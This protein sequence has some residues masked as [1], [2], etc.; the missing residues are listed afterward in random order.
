MRILLILLLVTTPLHAGD[1]P[2]F[3]GPAG[4]N[5]SP[6]KGLLTAWPKEGL[7]KLWDCPLGEGYGPPSAAGGKLFHFDLVRGKAVLTARDAVTGKHLWAYDYPCDYQDAFGYEGTRCCPVNDNDRVYIYGPEGQLHCV[8][9]AD[10]KKIWTVDTFKEFNVHPNF[11]GVSSVPI[12]EGDLLIVGVGGS[13]KGSQLVMSIENKS[14]NS[15][16]VAFDKKTGVVK[17]V[18][19]EELSSNSSPMIAVINKQRVGLY[20]ARGGLLGFEPVT[21][22]TLFHYPWRAKILES[23]NAANPVVIDDTVLISES[24]QVGSVLLKINGDKAEPVWTDRDKGRDDKSLMAHFATPIH[25][26]GYLYAAS[27]RHSA[28]ADLRC[29]DA[30]TG[31]VMWREKKTRWCTLLQVDGHILSLHEDGDLRLWKVN[32][33]KYEEV[34]RW[35]SPDLESP[36]WAPPVLSDGGLYVRGKE[37]L[38][39]YQL[40]TK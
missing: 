4:T 17:Y 29:L 12:V 40:M 2:K 20:F 35:T 10:G 3:L 15:A 34:A 28:D 1:W 30:K 32:P 7:K 22:K 31:E 19:G 25:V 39:C 11:F 24:Y 5:V 16:I 13:P 36:C 27:S 8:T 14:A 38:V 9:V 37:K 26:D 18:S 6:E 21:G 23:V 33:K